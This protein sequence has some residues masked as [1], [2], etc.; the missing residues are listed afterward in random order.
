MTVHRIIGT[1]L[2]RI[3][4]N[5]QPCIS[6]CF[7][8]NDRAIYPDSISHFV[9]VSY[10]IR[11]YI[12]ARTDR[13]IYG[14]L[15]WTAARTANFLTAQ[16]VSLFGPT[17]TSNRLNVTGPLGC[18]VYIH[19]IMPRKRIQPC[20]ILTASI[21]LLYASRPLFILTEIITNY[22]IRL[23]IMQGLKIERG[24]TKRVLIFNTHLL[25]SLSIQR[26]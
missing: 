6:G 21:C 24:I 4:T 19:G 1:L 5:Q 8:V 9:N 15:P 16:T 11:P 13:D 14:P 23:L 12:P 17:A 20:L 2:D 3:S 10:R 26:T 18:D 7:P 25:L 22:L